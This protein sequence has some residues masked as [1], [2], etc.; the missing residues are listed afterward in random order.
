MGRAF[1][2]SLELPLGDDVAIGL[3]ATHDGKIDDQL[4]ATF[5]L[6]LESGG[7]DG[8]PG[9]EL[10][11]FVDLDLLVL[12]VERDVVVAALDVAVVEDLHGAALVADGDEAV[13][14]AGFEGGSV[15]GGPLD[16]ER[17]VG[18]AP[19][20]ALGLRGRFGEVGGGGRFGGAD[21]GAARRCLHPHHHH[22]P[23]HPTHHHRHIRTR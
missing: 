15:G 17:F 1:A 16:D 8:E 14:G 21:L 9:V 23:G 3:V 2:A 18:A 13:A 10:I 20:A 6:A 22:H 19:H 5:E 4:A 7:A 11:G 12:G